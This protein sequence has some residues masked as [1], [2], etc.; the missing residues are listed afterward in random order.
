[1][2][3]VFASKTSLA[4]KSHLGIFPAMQK[5]CRRQQRSRKECLRLQPAKALKFFTSHSDDSNNEEEDNNSNSSYSSSKLPP[6]QR[7]EDKNSSGKEEGPMADMWDRTLLLRRQ[8]TI[9]TDE[10]DFHLAILIKSELFSIIAKL[11]TKYKQ[12]YLNIETLMD[13]TAGIVTKR[14]ALEELRLYGDA[15]TL[16]IVSS[17]LHKDS[18][19]KKEAEEAAAAIRHRSVSPAVVELCRTGA[20]HLIT[21]LGEEDEEEIDRVGEIAVAVYSAALEEDKHCATALAGRGAALYC[22]RQYEAAAEDLEAAV[23]LD[24]W[25][26]NAARILALTRG[27]LKQ[28]SLAKAALGA[29]AVLN[30]SLVEDRQHN[31]TRRVIQKW[32]DEAHEWRQTYLRVREEIEG[33]AKLERLLAQ[34]PTMMTDS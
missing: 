9:A 18:K 3:L 21:L 22:L 31:A 17:L 23:H 5:L 30:P 13:P 10:N 28:F 25:N 27:Q 12:L 20:L 26:T 11:S 19:L 7:Q 14:A 34:T 15:S 16:P 4:P 1:M 29:A 32:E 2:Q 6:P 33:K 8:L 24:P